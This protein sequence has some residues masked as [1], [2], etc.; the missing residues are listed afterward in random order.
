MINTDEVTIEKKR[1]DGE[2]E[3]KK[4]PQGIEP[5]F[6]WEYRRMDEIFEAMKRYSAA[7]QSIPLEWIVE[8]DDL[9][10]S[11]LN[12]SGRKDKLCE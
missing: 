2:A 6:S 1:T 3:N 7:K 4:P 9:Y 11:M 10:V 8:L 5:R 12:L